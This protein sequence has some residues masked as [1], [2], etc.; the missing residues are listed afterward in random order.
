MRTAAELTLGREADAVPKA[1]RFVGSSLGGEPPGT[2]HAVELVVTELVTNALFHGRP[3]VHIRL[4]D[5]GGSI[6]VEVEDTGADLPV[7]GIRDHDSMTGRGLAVVAALSSSWGIDTGRAAGKVVW[8]QVGGDAHAIIG[9]S[10][11][12]DAWV[13]AG[14]TPVI[15]AEAVLA[16]GVGRH[17]EPVYTVRLQGVPTGLLLAAKSH[18]DN[19]VRELT[20][21]QRGEATSGATLPP[22]IVRLI[23]AVTVQFAGA[24]SEIKRQAVEAARRGDALTDLELHLPVSYAEAGEQYLEALEEA[25][26]YAHAARLLTLA[27]PLSHQAFRR[28]YVRSLV[29]QLRALGS[30]RVPDPPE[31]LP[32]VLASRLDE[33]EEALHRRSGA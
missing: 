13:P 33:M 2:V 23:G 16:A 25:D 31:P 28:W 12:D 1:R 24:R 18:I 22:A 6:R 9:G 30:G 7:L 5:L 27:P 26:R 29:E 17:T 15:T 14:A 11:D 19:M 21:L 8:S 10:T 3:P 20:L 4:I 32:S